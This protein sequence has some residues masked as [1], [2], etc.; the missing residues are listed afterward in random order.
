MPMPTALGATASR[1]I[2]SQCFSGGEIDELRN[3]SSKDLRQF[4]EALNRLAAHRAK[5]SIEKRLSL[6]EIGDLAGRSG[7]LLGITL[8]RKHYQGAVD[9]TLQW[10][11]KF[12]PEVL[13][14][15]LNDPVKANLTKIESNQS[16]LTKAN[17]A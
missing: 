17:L 13:L 3:P 14:D 7:E 4:I 1:R 9:E 12:A 16:I 10:V 2:E 8:R 15:V 11:R 5:L 6:Q